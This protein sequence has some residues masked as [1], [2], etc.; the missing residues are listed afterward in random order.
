MNWEYQIVIIEADQT[1]NG[2]VSLNSFGASGWELVSAQYVHGV[3][4]CF[5]KRQAV[6]P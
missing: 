6:S 5:L 1:A 2:V 4:F 3:F